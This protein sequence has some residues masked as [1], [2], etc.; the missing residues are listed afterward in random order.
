MGSNVISVTC[1]VHGSLAQANLATS[2]PGISSGVLAS[3]TNDSDSAVTPATQCTCFRIAGGG[4]YV[5]IV[6]A[7]EA[8]APTETSFDADDEAML[9]ADNMDGVWQP[10]SHAEN[11]KVTL[12]KGEMIWRV[13][14][15]V[16]RYS[17][18]E[19]FHK[20]LDAYSTA[21]FQL[22]RVRTTYSV[23]SRNVRLRQLA[24][25]RGL[26]VRE[27]EN[28]DPRVLAETEQ[29]GMNGLSRAHLVPEE[30]EWYSKTFLCTHGWKRR[31]RGSGQRVS[32]IVRATE[33]PAKICATLQRTDGSSKWSVV[34][35]KHLAEHN[36][37]L[38]EELY[39]Q[40][41]EVRRVRDPEVLAQAEKLWR[42]GASRRRVF[43]FFKERSPHQLIL[44]KDVH[45]LV[46]RWQSRE[47]R[48]R[49]DQQ[50]DSNEDQPVQQHSTA[51][52]CSQ[53]G[54]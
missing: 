45:N 40:Y 37:E 3:T 18:W 1:R 38:S 53:V 13:P 10:S 46:Q 48:P 21:T 11:E 41:S 35:T 19:D 39:L 14:R 27:G 15:I 16:R 8:L 34:V 29:K 4:T 20:Y 31:S 47:R 17:S 12:E 26:I 5:T 44:M 23:R 36:H 33:C 30:Y 32:H 49:E 54:R 50:Q 22:Y 2:K 25:S 9:Y 6:P 28:D 42:D 7:S 52:C 51:G 24:A 43:E